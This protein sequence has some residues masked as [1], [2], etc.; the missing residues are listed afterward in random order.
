MRLR[1]TLAVIGSALVLSSL[2]AQDAGKHPYEVKYVDN[3]VPVTR[4][5]DGKKVLFV[6]VQFQILR[7]GD[8]GVVT[9]IGKKDIKVWEEGKEVAGFTINEPRSRDPLTAM[10][11]MDIS[12][13]MKEH[14][15]AEQARIASHSF[16]DKLDPKADCGLILFN[17]E[18]IDPII[19]PLRDA[20]GD[21]SA[22]RDAIR[23]LIQKQYADPRGG[24]AYLD[25]AYN[26]IEQ[27]HGVK[28][29]R[30]V[31]VM[32]DG[33]DLNSKHSLEEVIEFAVMRET[34]VYTIGVGEPG[35]NEKVTTVMVVDRSGSMRDRAD[36]SD[37]ISK[38]DA[39]KR[40]AGRFIDIM[41]PEART[42]IMAFSDTVDRADAFT[43]DKDALKAKIKKLQPKGET[44]L[45]DA[46]FQALQTLEAERPVGKKAVIV[47]TDGMDNL[48]G[49]RVEEVIQRARQ[50]ATPLHLLGLGPVKF[51]GEE[52]L[53][54]VVMKKMANE[55]GGTYHHA[56]NQQRLYEVFEDLSIELHDDGIDE[57]SLKL[58]AEKT[59]GRY[60]PAHDI[61][62][63]ELGF[64]SLA[65]QLQNTY[66]VTF[67]SIRSTNDGTAR[68]IDI[69]VF[70]PDGVPLSGKGTADYSVHGVVVPELDTPVYVAYLVALCG[71]LAVPAGLRRL[72]RFYGGT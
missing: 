69:Q 19:P 66:T 48:S 30:A 39:L 11:A 14:G 52:M 36:T 12:G 71:L 28:G 35:K 45:F 2:P 33:V 67:P 72:Y 32:T 27:M 68:G 15:K 62:S 9:D 38:I 25:A 47:I 8:H 34:P 58:M 70:S 43:N 59:G 26:A 44:A 54:E 40:A 51:R 60:I 13:S 55:T 21:Q 41:R 56:A 63:L 42:T 17:H 65:D 50:M 18:M 5:Q 46:I 10:L 53:D 49:H 57:K 61:S 1:L 31:V 6:T 37:E 23:K 20:K 22:N 3:V 64:A 4:E 7:T 24:T 29:R 16:L